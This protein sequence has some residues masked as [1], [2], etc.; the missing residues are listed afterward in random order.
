L[1][2]ELP[3]Q[4][5]DDIALELVRIKQLKTGTIQDEAVEFL[6]TQQGRLP[7]VAA[8]IGLSHNTLYDIVSGRRQTMKCVVA[9]KILRY[10]MLLGESL[11]SCQLN[12]LYQK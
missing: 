9:E 4:Y 11:L 1:T 8:D 2:T 6:L 5:D 7:R 3:D 12:R 10:K